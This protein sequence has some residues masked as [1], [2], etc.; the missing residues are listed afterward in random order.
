MKRS[1]ILP[2]I[3][4]LTLQHPNLNQEIVHEVLRITGINLEKVD[5]KQLN[6]DVK[7]FL[8]KFKSKFIAANRTYSRFQSKE[9]VWLNCDFP[10]N[11]K[12]PAPLPGPGRPP[13][14]WDDL[15]E[16]SKR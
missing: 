5:I 9:E 11:L 13:K 12:L 4:E 16:K 1:D 10:V 6:N 8:T 2:K 3:K 14:C 7:V 15:G